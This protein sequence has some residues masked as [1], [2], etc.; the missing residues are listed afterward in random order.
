MSEP[1][2]VTLLKSLMQVP[3][4]SDHEQDIARWLDNHL[5]TLG[6]TVERIPIAPGSTREN[7][8]AYLGSTRRGAS[9]SH[10]AHGHRPAAYP[11]AR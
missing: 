8:Y 6:Y 9:L 1:P 4:T 10:C 5:S 11:T 3:S 2:V 7:V